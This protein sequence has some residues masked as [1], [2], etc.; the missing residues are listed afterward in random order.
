[1]CENRTGKRGKSF[2]RQAAYAKASAPK[3]RESTY[4]NITASMLKMAS[5]SSILRVVSG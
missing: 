4:L 2:N 3:M 1:M 5:I